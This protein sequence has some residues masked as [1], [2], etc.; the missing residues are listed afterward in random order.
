MKI[1]CQTEQLAK[2]VQI[3]S[4]HSDAKQFFYMETSDGQLT[5]QGRFASMLVRYAIPAEVKEAGRALADNCKPL[6]MI[7]KHLGEEQ[8]ELGFDSDSRNFSVAGSAQSYSFSGL[9]LTNYSLP[10]V[11]LEEL[12]TPLTRPGVSLETNSLVNA[13]KNIKFAAEQGDMSFKLYK[14]EEKLTYIQRDYLRGVFLEFKPD[15]YRLAATDGRRLTTTTAVRSKNL[16]DTDKFD[17]FYNIVIPNQVCAKLIE[18]VEIIRI[19][20][21][22]LIPGAEHARFEFEGGSIDFKL[23]GQGYPDIQKIMPEPY[24]TKI[25]AETECLKTA[26][27]QVDLAEPRD[28]RI[29]LQITGEQLQAQAVDGQFLKSA[30]VTIP[31]KR[32]GQD[33]DVF[34]RAKYLLDVLNHTDSH[35]VTIEFKDPLSAVVIKGK[36][37]YYNLIMPMKG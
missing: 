37:G 6:E 20:Q 4:N 34:V 31:V 15:Q 32:E 12:D 14:A 1:K 28:N 23:T 26:I 5:L 18:I 2:A 29:K 21:L 10:D 13:M 36:D 16:A 9:T 19:Q 22:Q 30:E 7:L 35:K 24:P 11:L 17:F 8:V 27:E 3:V 33:I 25:I